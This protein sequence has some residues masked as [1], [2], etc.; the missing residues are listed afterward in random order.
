MSSLQDKKIE[1]CS[2]LK[3]AANNKFKSECKDRNK[4]LQA[5]YCEKS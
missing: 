3:A 2:K 1:D 5:K 4:H